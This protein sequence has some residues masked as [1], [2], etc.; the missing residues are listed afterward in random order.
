MN[1]S[2]AWLIT[3]GYSAVV[4]AIIKVSTRTSDSRGLWWIR[5]S[6]HRR[7]SRSKVRSDRFMVMGVYQQTRVP[8]IER[9]D[10]LPGRHSRSRCAPATHSRNLRVLPSVNAHDTGLITPHRERLPADPHLHDV[11]AAARPP[12]AAAKPAV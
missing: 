10:P 12:I 6:R 3:M 5:C 9:A 4:P 1:M 7:P 11:V 8:A 2:N